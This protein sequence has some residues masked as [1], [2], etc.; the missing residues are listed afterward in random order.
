MSELDDSLKPQLESLEKTYYGIEESARDIYAYAE[1]LEFDPHRLEEMESRLELIRNLKR[2]FGKSLTEIIAYQAQ[3]QKELDLV[4]NFQD[5]QLELQKTD[6]RMPDLLR[7]AGCPTIRGP[8][9]G[10]LKSF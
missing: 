10:S 1:K 5:R 8:Q 6:Q 4:N 3:S 2:K 7:K 9:A